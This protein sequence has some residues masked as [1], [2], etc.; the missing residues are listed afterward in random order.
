MPREMRTAAPVR[1]EPRGRQHVDHLDPR[2]LA[3]VATWLAPSSGAGAAA[4][5]LELLL[6]D[7][8]EQ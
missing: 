7:E 4:A 5:C 3:E 1:E 6:G 8:D 2:P